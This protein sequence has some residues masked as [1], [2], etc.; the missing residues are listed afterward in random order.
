MSFQ[1]MAWAI[2]QR[3]G[4]PA[5][6]LL[7]LVLS[8]Y[9]DED[10]RAWPTQ[11]TLMADTGMSERSVRDKTDWLQER[12]FLTV[13]TIRH[14]YGTK[15]IYTLNPPAKIADPPAKSA[16]AHRQKLQ[17]PPADPAAYPINKPI[18][19][20]S[21]VGFEEFWQACPRRIGKAAAEKAYAKAVKQTPHQ[22]I[23]AGIRRYAASRAGQDEQY[24]VHPATWLNQ[25]RWDDEPAG[26]SQQGAGPKRELTEAE[27]WENAR[28]FHEFWEAKEK[29]EAKNG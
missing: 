19:K 8:N 1:A 28:R 17:N 10:Y 20:D 7:L 22:T 5:S 25:G 11:K 21:F 12:G 14:A 13:E 3:A 6:R 23:M 18:I 9:A 4:D 29:A 27:K 24:T 15:L 2:Q 16:G 26:G